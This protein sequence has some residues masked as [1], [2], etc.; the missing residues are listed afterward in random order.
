MPEILRI[1]LITI[2]INLRATLWDNRYCMV[3][4]VR[5]DDAAR[6]NFVDRSR[7]VF[8]RLFSKLAWVDRNFSSAVSLTEHGFDTRVFSQLP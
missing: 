7:V 4:A 5:T 6:K 1:G 3:S 2:V 8:H